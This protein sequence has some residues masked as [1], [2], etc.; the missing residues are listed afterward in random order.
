M[1]KPSPSYAGVEVLVELGE[2]IRRARKELGMSQEQLALSAELDRSY[3]G[4]VER[5]EHN[6][7]IMT[8]VKLANALGVH[9]RDLL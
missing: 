1:A 2:A 9:P 7:T 4:G 3:I 8:L 5:G 6:L